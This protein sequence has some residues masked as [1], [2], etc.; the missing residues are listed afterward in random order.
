MLV[1]ELFDIEPSH[2][3]TAEISRRRIDYGEGYAPVGRAA[4]YLAGY[5]PGTSLG[6]H[7]EFGV[8]GIHGENLL[9]RYEGGWR[10]GR[11]HGTA[12]T[13]Q[14]FA[15]RR[16]EPYLWVWGGAFTEIEICSRYL[17]PLPER[18]WH[19]NWRGINALAPLQA[20]R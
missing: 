18:Y 1:S 13:W 15:K 10:S 7:A 5:V 6:D 17:Q 4:V 8:H 12:P 14:S 2:T 11:E 19:P 3:S 16:P 20:G 9:V